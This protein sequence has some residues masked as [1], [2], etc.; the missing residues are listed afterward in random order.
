[1]LEYEDP[2]YRR[3]RCRWVPDLSMKN[4]AAIP[5]VNFNLVARERSS[6]AVESDRLLSYTYPTATVANGSGRNRTFFYI[7]LTILLVLE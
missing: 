2:D 4:I 7:D 1:M 5:P 6:G 3:D